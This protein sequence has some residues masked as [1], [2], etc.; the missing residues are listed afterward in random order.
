MGWP[1][2]EPLVVGGLA[3]LCCVSAALGL[4]FIREK[5]RRRGRE[6]NPAPAQVAAPDSA[7]LSRYLPARLACWDIIAPYVRCSLACLF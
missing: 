5:K 7:Q 2:C 4:F 6:D 1:P 3:L